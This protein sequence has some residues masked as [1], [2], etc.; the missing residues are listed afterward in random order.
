MFQSFNNSWNLVKASFNVLRADKELLIFPLI[1]A[2]GVIIVTITFMVPFAIVSFGEA[3]A[4]ETSRGGVSDPAAGV[5]FLSILLA[6]IFYIVMYFVIFYCNTAL[7]GAAMI[8]LKGGDPTVGDG[9]RIANERLGKIAG[10]AVVSATVGTVLAWIRDQGWLGRLVAGILGFAWNVATYLSVPVL[11][12]ENVGP[13]D[14]VKRSIEL[15]KKTWGEQLVAQFG[16]GAVFGWVSFAV[17][18]FIGFPLFFL[19]FSTESISLVITAFVVVF[20]L[21]ALLGLLSGALTGIYQAAL[22]RYATEGTAGDGF[23]PAVI[24]GAF[25]PKRG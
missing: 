24:E 15:L 11:V 2:I 8:R 4:Q 3:M 25:K 18:V 10:Y 13:I 21:L 19:A 17:I 6:F 9:F 22:Y 12:V 23:D 16:I 20:I 5:S 1:S 7:V 14:A